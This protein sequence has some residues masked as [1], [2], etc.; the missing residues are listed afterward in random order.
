[1]SLGKQCANHGI[2]ETICSACKGAAEERTR[3]LEIIASE[4]SELINQT[5]YLKNNGGKTWEIN[6]ASARIRLCDKLTHIVTKG[7]YVVQDN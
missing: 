5:A 2:P 7:P 4:R 6:R 3:I 1:M